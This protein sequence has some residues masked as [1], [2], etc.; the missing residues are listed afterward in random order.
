MP[1]REI[2]LVVA[3][4]V[5]V[6]GGGIGGLC[7]AIALRRT[8]HEVIVCERTGRLEAAGAG[9]TLFTNAM[10][11]LDVLGM[12][13]AVAA[14]AAQ[15][16]R[17][18]ILLSDGRQLASTPR[19]LFE[20]AVAVHRGDLQAVLSGAA[21]EL[22]LGTEVAGVEDSVVRLA[23]VVPLE[24]VAAR[25][26]AR[27]RGRIRRAEVERS[28]VRGGVPRR[29]VHPCE[30]AR[31][32][33]RRGVR[34]L[35]ARPWLVVPEVR[36]GLPPGLTLAEVGSD[37]AVPELTEA[38]RAADGCGALTIVELAEQGLRSLGVRTWRRAAAGGVQPADRVRFGQR[39]LR[40]G[41]GKE[42]ALA[43]PGLADDDSRRRAG[44]AAPN[45]VPQCGQ[46][47]RPADERVHAHERTPIR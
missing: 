11:G 7:A 2:R 32:K 23:D 20:G 15:A 41:F 10:R 9:I 5:V 13:D 25:R 18:A 4:R 12:R 45:D 33:T 14:R 46:F 39:R 34:G 19:D 24:A 22:R 42:P 35:L 31:L 1:R 26:R 8:G 43:A 17:V 28:T 6:V 3:M 44:T 38:A 36:A 47:L 29:R 27:R 21:G 40:A 37:R 16:E 30:L